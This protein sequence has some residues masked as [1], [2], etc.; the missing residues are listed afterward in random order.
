MA[1][2]DSLKVV[3]LRDFEE[4]PPDDE[5]EHEKVSR[6]S[7][8]PDGAALLQ[9]RG[10]PRGMP[11]SAAHPWSWADFFVIPPLEASCADV[12]EPFCVVP[13]TASSAR[14]GHAAQNVAAPLPA[15]ALEGPADLPKSEAIAILPLR[16]KRMGASAASAQVGQRD[17][18][19]QQQPQQVPS[20][21]PPRQK[22]AESPANQRALKFY[23]QP[24]DDRSADG[25]AQVDVI[26][27]GFEVLIV[28]RSPSPTPR[29]PSD[30]LPVIREDGGEPALLAAVPCYASGG[31]VAKLDEPN[32]ASV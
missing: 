32:E 20:G 22:Q 26:E 5:H 30:A 15:V 8:M 18:P 4:K 27:H 12:K 19:L 28:R 7:K 17:H 10:V 14:N 23:P 2:D 16:L 11:H 31:M 6:A 21:L 3:R 24:Y 1:V 25:Y 9:P 13:S 29:C